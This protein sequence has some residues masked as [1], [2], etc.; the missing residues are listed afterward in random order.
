MKDLVGKRFRVTDDNGSFLWGG[1]VISRVGGLYLLAKD[2]GD[3][4]FASGKE[5]KGWEFYD[6]TP[7]KECAK[8]NEALT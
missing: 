3:E 7:C 2:N 5:M 6:G 8:I 4:R 1:R